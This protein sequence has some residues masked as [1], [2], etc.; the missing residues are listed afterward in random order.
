[1]ETMITKNGRTLFVRR[2]RLCDE[3]KVESARKCWFSFERIGQ[4]R[5]DY[6]CGTATKADAVRHASDAAG[7]RWDV[8]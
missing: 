3:L 7:V 4:E 5:I 6:A 1:M 2:A 8:V